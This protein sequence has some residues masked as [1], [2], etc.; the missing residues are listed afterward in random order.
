MCVC[1]WVGGTNVQMDVPCMFMCFMYFNVAIFHVFF[2]T[3]K[4]F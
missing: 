2:M 1:V 3:K 4:P